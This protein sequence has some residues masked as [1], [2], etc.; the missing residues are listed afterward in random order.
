MTV[1]KEG[2]LEQ[3]PYLPQ[4]S[5]SGSQRGHTHMGKSTRDGSRQE[6]PPPCPNCKL[7]EPGKRLTLGMLSTYQSK[8]TLKSTSSQ[9]PF[10][11][12]E[13]RGR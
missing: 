11:H 7:E 4:T 12:Q 9:T 6:R 8:Q 2:A 5:E 3:S 1:T 13:G 10:S